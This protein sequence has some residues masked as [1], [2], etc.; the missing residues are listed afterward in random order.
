MNAAVFREQLLRCL[1][2]HK[3]CIKQPKRTIYSSV[4]PGGRVNDHLLLLTSS[5]EVAKPSRIKIS[6]SS[7]CELHTDPRRRWQTRWQV[8]KVKAE[9]TSAKAEALTDHGPTPGWRPFRDDTDPYRERGRVKL[10]VSLLA[11]LS[12]VAALM[13]QC[14]CW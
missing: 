1:R 10:P 14:W 5:R 6:R 13:S 8:F 11:G 3:V 4:H 2:F 12:S 9:K 7:T